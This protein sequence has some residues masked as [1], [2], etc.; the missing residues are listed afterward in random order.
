MTTHSEVLPAVYLEAARATGPSWKKPRDLE[1]VGQI[2]LRELLKRLR[3]HEGQLSAQIKGLY[4]RLKIF[5]GKTSA[6]F[7]ELALE[8][9]DMQ[10]LD[11]GIGSALNFRLG[12]R[13]VGSGTGTFVRC[14]SCNSGIWRK[15]NIACRFLNIAPKKEQSA[16]AES[17]CM[18][19]S[20]SISD[21]KTLSRKYWKRIQTLKDH[22]R[23][24]RKHIGYVSVLI[25][26]TFEFPEIPN[27]PFGDERKLE[28]GD[29]VRVFVTSPCCRKNSR[30][31][32]QPGTV[33][34]KDGSFMIVCFDYPI[35]AA[36]T[37][38][39][40][41]AKIASLWHK[42]VWWSNQTQ[43]TVMTEKTYKEIRSRSEVHPDDGLLLAWRENLDTDFHCYDELSQT[44]VDVQGLTIYDALVNGMQSK[45]APEAKRLM[46]A[47][48]ARCRLRLDQKPNITARMIV[49]SYQQ[50][51]HRGHQ[52][53]K[54]LLRAKDT[55]LMRYS[56]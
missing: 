38:M 1:R 5:N 27:N 25:D 11:P 28:Y 34:E 17:T 22:R 10:S 43:Y 31:T 16:P 18:L 9:V 21:F 48:E 15:K 12:H 46:S 47:D 24:V 44:H 41:R 13:S 3:S 55:L 35:L 36:Q 33:L 50:E 52:D 29:R 32:W 45:V 4:E 23:I 8:S 37:K 42:H 20:Y 53:E 30:F 7:D 51:R 2:K 56:G 14:G 19:R 49:T 40:Q 26:Q 54:V 6:H 39:S